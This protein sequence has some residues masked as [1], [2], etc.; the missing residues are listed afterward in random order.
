MFVILNTKITF[1]QHNSLLGGVEKMLMQGKHLLTVHPVCLLTIN[2]S[3][4]L[5]CGE[6]KGLNAINGND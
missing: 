1:K 2:S 3:L 5:Q 6:W 4:G